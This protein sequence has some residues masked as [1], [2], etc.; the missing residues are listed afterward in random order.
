MQQC[1]RSA[2]LERRLRTEMP[3]GLQITFA[4]L[5][6]AYGI[7]A[8]VKGLEHNIVDLGYQVHTARDCSGCDASNLV[9]GFDA[10]GIQ[11]AAGR[12][13]T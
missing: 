1:G 10:N 6:D 3:R 8:T 9:Q 2:V 12:N 7:A 13:A 11:S 4:A 5:L